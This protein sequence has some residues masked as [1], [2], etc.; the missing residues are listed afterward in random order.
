MAPVRFNGWRMSK[1]SAQLSIHLLVA[2]VLV[3]F[4][5][6]TSSSATD[7]E[8]Q[9]EKSRQMDRDDAVLASLEAEERRAWQ[10]FTARYKGQI[11][12]GVGCEVCP[13]LCRV[14][15]LS[16]MGENDFQQAY[17]QMVVDLND[18]RVNHRLRVAM[19]EHRR[20]LCVLQNE[21]VMLEALAP[22]LDSHEL[23]AVRYH[24]AID[25]AEI[26]HS[27]ERPRQVL[28]EVAAS[29]G[30]TAGLARLRIEKWDKSGWPGE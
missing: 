28:E 30:F 24:A 11:E 13:E 20:L 15:D 27:N 1:A 7:W 6:N 23:S 25:M 26:S 21:P 8:A 18:S 2:G 12:D 3:A 4:G 19:H 22:L 5:C 16:P 29:G 17:R 9:K 10:A 14:A